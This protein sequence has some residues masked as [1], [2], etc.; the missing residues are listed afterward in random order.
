M[1]SLKLV[2][3]G[4][5]T[6]LS[7]LLKGFKRFSMINP[8]AA[9]IINI[10]EL[11]AIVTVSDDGGSTGRLVDEFD[12]LPP[13]DIRKLLVSLSESDKLVSSLFEYRFSSDGPLGGHNIGN[14][15]LIALTELN[16]NNFPRAIELASQ[17][18]A[19]RGQI[20]P[21]SLQPTILCAELIDGEIIRGESMIPERKN[22]S[23]IQKIFLESRP[24]GK[25]SEKYEV[26]AHKA[27]VDSIN[28]AD[29]I[30]IGPGSLY[31]S[32]MPNLV[33]PEIREAL[34][35]SS[36][37]K[38]YI[39]NVMSQPGETDNY[40][41]TEHVN[42]ITSHANISLD[43]VIVNDGIASP[44]VLKNYIQKKISG[45]LDLIRKYTDE[46]L[47]MSNKQ[48]DDLTTNPPMDFFDHISTLSEQISQLSS[49][50]TQIAN[51]SQVQVLFDPQ[52]DHLGGAELVTADM[53]YQTRVLVDQGI[54]LDVVRHDPIKLA[55]TLVGVIGDHFDFS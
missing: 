51:T 26:K 46:G 25:T 8:D 37:I 43:Y 17:L 49:G 28:N 1:K 20:I 19:V 24:N 27:S 22:R 18:L 52:K 50:I 48:E 10:D 11:S 55:T 38:V 3:V 21:V 32:I 29:V 15:L 23:P 40:S 30:I 14:L 16:D 44:E 4:G 33:Y 31:T 45:Q 9:N 41:V 12:V 39:C 5:G 42:A 47:T 36:A 2:C 6:G 13:G 7:S 53:I 54:E 34:R 35:N